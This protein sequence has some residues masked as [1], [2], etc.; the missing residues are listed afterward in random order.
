M[1]VLE[2]ERIAK[3]VRIKEGKRAT[4]SKSA[5]EKSRCGG[6]QATVYAELSFHQKN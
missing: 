4:R 1:C 2:Y 5:G 6:S 3:Y